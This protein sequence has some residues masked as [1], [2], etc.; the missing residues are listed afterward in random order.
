MYFGGL[1]PQF[2]SD[3]RRIIDYLNQILPD[4]SFNKEFAY[5]CEVIP[6][7]FKHNEQLIQSIY[8]YILSLSVHY[9]TKR[10][11]LRYLFPF[12]AISGNQFSTVK[13][14]MDRCYADISTITEG[15]VGNPIIARIQE[16][17]YVG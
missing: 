5:V 7:K 10:I 15:V 12:L 3:F 4:I 17:S 9:E 8:G 16:V 14:I 13:D 2:V 6:D 1:D 11:N